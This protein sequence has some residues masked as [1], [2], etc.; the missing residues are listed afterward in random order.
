MDFLDR[1]IKKNFFLLHHKTYW[2]LVPWKL[3][4]H[5]RL[6]ATPWT[7]QSMEFSRPE[8]WSGKLFPS[9]QI[10]PIQGS[11]PGLLHCRQ[12]FYQLSHQGS[13]RILEWVAYPFS[14]GSSWPRNWTRVSWIACGFFTSYYLG[15]ISLFVTEL[16][17]L[18]ITL[19][20]KVFYYN[21]FI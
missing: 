3:L 4:S 21:N 6:F 8:Y 14:N 11:N 12:I 1:V 17:Q 20:F 13:P 7:I 18:I 19:F 9:W 2:I 16:L 5:V 15:F 10:F